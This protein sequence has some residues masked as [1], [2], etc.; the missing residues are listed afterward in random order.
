MDSPTVLRFRSHVASAYVQNL[1][2]HSPHV[3][4]M[5][6][7]EQQ[8]FLDGHHLPFTGGLARGLSRLGLPTLDVLYDVPQVQEAWERE[9]TLSS[10]WGRRLRPIGFRSIGARRGSSVIAAHRKGAGERSI[11]TCIF[12]RHAAH[13]HNRRATAPPDRAIGFRRGHIFRSI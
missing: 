3:A 8:E 10:I 5:G 9:T 1:Y 12:R 7:V 2:D 13:L 4:E 6:F 11:C